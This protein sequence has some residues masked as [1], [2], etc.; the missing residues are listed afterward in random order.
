DIRTIAELALARVGGFDVTLAASGPEALAA[1]DAGGPL[2]SCVLLDM[3]M[4]GMSGAEVAREISAHPR[5]T[6]LP[7]IFLTGRVGEGDVATYKELGAAG[8]IEK[9]FDPLDLPRRVRACIDTDGSG[10]G[11]EA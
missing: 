1:L 9:P 10:P 7:V 3:T 5:L 6:E 8:L 11:R 2:P 4:P